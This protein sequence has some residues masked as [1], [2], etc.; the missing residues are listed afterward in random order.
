MEK[1]KA[2]KWRGKSGAIYNV[3]DD[4]YGNP[5]WPFHCDTPLRENKHFWKADGAAWTG[6][7]SGGDDLVAEVPSFRV[8]DRVRCIENANGRGKGKFARVTDVDDYTVTVIVDAPFDGCGE[9]D[10]EWNFRADQLELAPLTIEAGKFYITRDGR[11]VG[12]MRDAGTAHDT[13]ETVMSADVS[14]NFRLFR[15]AGGAHL[16][17]TS[18]LDLI[19]E[20][21]AITTNAAAEVDNL[22]D[23]YGGG[24]KADSNLSV[25]ISADTSELDAGIDRVKKRLKKLAKRARKL[26]ISLDYSDLREAD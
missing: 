9:E 21:P 11:R 15:V 1:L 19:S 20:A 16:F 14:G 25:T 5:S 7:V 17:N 8:G 2:G 26:G 6:H 22:A 13:K 3:M 10:R 4:L 18:E 12:P 24:K 23:E